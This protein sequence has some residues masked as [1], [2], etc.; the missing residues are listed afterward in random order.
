MRLSTVVLVFAFF[1]AGAL[2][3]T[4]QEQDNVPIVSGGAGLFGQTQGGVNVFQPVIAPVVV[5]PLG[6]RWVIESRADLREVISRQDGTTGPYQG[7]FFG[8]LEY[9]QVD[10][11]ATSRLTITGGR[12]L[13]PFGIFNERISAI[14]INK[15]QDAPFIAAIGTGMGYSDGFMTRGAAISENNFVLN[16]AAYF[17]TLSTVSNLESQR[18]AGGRVGVFFPQIRLELGGSYRRTL[19]VPKSNSEGVDVTWEPYSVPLELRG[20]WA[21]SPSG[22]GYWIQASYRLLQFDGA[23]SPLGR[24]EPTFR[25]QQFFR[26]QIIPGDSLPSTSVWQPALA[27]NYYLPHEV[28]LNASYGRDFFSHAIDKN[29][30]EFGITYRFL[31]PMWPGESK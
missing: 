16:Y 5:V 23:D 13:T 19:Q 17:S 18:G 26:S 31:F 27:L 29:V 28:R 3:A 6:E 11:N 20:E 7:D 21:Q 24:L 2:V 4:A 1:F 10:F 14:W 8:T 15:F 12:F 30:W 22:N 25:A 9:L